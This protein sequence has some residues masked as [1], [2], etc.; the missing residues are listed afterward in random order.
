[1]ELNSPDS[2]FSLP[3]TSNSLNFKQPQS[4]IFNSGFNEDELL[5]FEHQENN[6]NFEQY[7][8]NK[9]KPRNLD[10]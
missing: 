6:N 9:R 3:N 2:N 8:V 5:L 10:V 4:L 7:Y 1:M